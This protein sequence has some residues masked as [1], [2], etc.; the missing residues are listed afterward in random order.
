[1]SRDHGLGGLAVSAG[2]LAALSSGPLRDHGG[3]DPA[4]NLGDAVCRE[5]GVYLL[6]DSPPGLRRAALEGRRTLR[7]RWRRRVLR[8]AG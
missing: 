2:Y 7:S 3:A 6:L 4:L 5:S 8:L 1:V